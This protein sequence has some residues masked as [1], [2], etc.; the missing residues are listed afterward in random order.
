MY[1]IL[2]NN[3][4]SNN[5]GKEGKKRK[6][7]ENEKKNVRAKKRK[8]GWQSLGFKTYK[9]YLLAKKNGEL[10]NIEKEETEETNEDNEET[11]N[12]KKV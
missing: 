4:K 5:S 3:W 12:E 7:S 6:Q 10:E 2:G 8:G 11:L 9:D 1:S